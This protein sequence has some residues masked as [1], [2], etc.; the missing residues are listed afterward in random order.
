MKEKVY[1]G[2]TCIIAALGA[3]LILIP[4]IPLF[5]L[6]MFLTVLGIPLA[7]MFGWLMTALK[8]KRSQKKLVFYGIR[9]ATRWPLMICMYCLMAIIFSKEQFDEEWQSCRNKYWDS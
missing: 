4:L 9:K 5:L 1:N 7:Y 2:I 6:G 3:A 8:V